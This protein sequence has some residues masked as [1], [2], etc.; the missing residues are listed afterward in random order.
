[1]ASRLPSSGAPSSGP[2]TFPGH[3]NATTAAAPHNSAGAEGVGV[4]GIAEVY[5]KERPGLLADRGVKG[6]SDEA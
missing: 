1:M 4:A 6:A 2:I 3:H 5:S